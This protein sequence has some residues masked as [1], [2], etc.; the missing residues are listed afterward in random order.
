MELSFV[1]SPLANSMSRLGS[2]YADA[3]TAATA[4]VANR[5]FLIFL[6]RA[7][8]RPSAPL[9]SLLVNFDDEKGAPDH[10][11]RRRPTR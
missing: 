10:S 6:P 7:A 9:G 8:S 11:A 4:T 5:R 2:A 1:Q 3:D